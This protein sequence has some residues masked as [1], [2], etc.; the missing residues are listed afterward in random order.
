MNHFPRN[1]YKWSR[2]FR[3]E[4]S[5]LAVW[6]TDQL[7]HSHSHWSDPEPTPRAGSGVVRIDPLRFL[8]GCRTQGD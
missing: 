2:A 5:C 7:F 6:L 8:A 1:P 4:V 3:A